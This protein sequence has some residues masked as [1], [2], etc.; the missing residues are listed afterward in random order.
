MVNTKCRLRQTYATLQSPC[1]NDRCVPCTLSVLVSCIQRHE[2]TEILQILS[3][4]ITL[5]RQTANGQAVLFHHANVTQLLR[6]VIQICRHVSKKRTWHVVYLARHSCARARAQTPTL[7]TS[8]LQHEVA[9]VW[10]NKSS[11]GGYMAEASLRAPIFTSV[12]WW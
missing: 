7:I 10:V 8:P 6:P 5:G 3:T 4:S 12:L 2:S 1:H 9:K 11:V